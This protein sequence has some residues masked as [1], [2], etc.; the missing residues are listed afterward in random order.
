MGTRVGWQEGWHDGCEVG[1]DGFDVG[2]TEG[3]MVG[4]RVG[5]LEGREDG[6][7]DG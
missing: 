1:M 2:W 5:I 4:M 7:C 3:C 6:C